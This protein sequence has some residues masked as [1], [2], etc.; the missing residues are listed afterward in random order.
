M[1]GVL[2]GILDA[3]ESPDIWQSFFFYQR[4]NV[5]T[6]FTLLQILQPELE[7][8]VESEDESD[9]GG[10]RNTGSEQISAVA[11]RVL[12]GLRHYSSWLTSNAA[13][14]TAQLGDSSLIVQIKELWKI[15]ASTLTL[16][17]STFEVS[18][19]PSIEYLLEEDEDTLGFKPFINDRAKRRYYYQDSIAQKPKWHQN[20]VER[21]HPNVEM[22]G[23]IRDFLTEGLLLAV[24]EVRGPRGLK[25][26]IDFL[27]RTYQSISSRVPLHSPIVKKVCLR[28]SKQARPATKLPWRQQ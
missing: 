26:T 20:G 27:S 25:I 23:R 4:L 11:R 17:A 21:H 3:P 19:L 6:M 12:P 2:T 24:D 16:L 18:D 9:L 10:A 28:K 7:R 1:R 8:Q 5:K 15:Y 13:V 14:L 22:F